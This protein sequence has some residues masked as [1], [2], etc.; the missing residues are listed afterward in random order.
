MPRRLKAAALSLALMGVLLLVAC[1]PRT[2]EPIPLATPAASPTSDASPTPEPTPTPVAVATTAPP[3][4]KEPLANDAE[5]TARQRRIFEQLWN[6]LDTQYVYADFNGV[7]WDAVYVEF[8]ARIEGGLS[9]EDFWRAMSEMID[10]LGDDHSTF[11]TP[12]EAREQDEQLGGTLTYIGIGVEAGVQADKAQA[13][14]YNV[15]PGSSAEQAGLRPHDA[16]LAIDGEAVVLP[17]GT[18]NLDKLRGELGS[19]V[20]L[21]VRSPG[22]LPRQVTL[23]RRRVN[24]TLQVT[25]RLLSGDSA[26]R[27]GYMM[28]PNLWDTAIESSAR[29][30]LAALMAGGRLDGLIIDMRTN[31]GGL[32]TNLLA[33]LGFFVHGSHGEFIGRDG[34]RALTV[35]PDPIGNSQ[36]VPLIILISEASVSYAEVFT[37]VLREAGRARL[38][39]QTSAGN[40]E[41]IYGYD[42]EDGSRAWI[43]RETFVPPSGDDWE[44]AGLD[45]DVRLD[46]D[47]DEFT[48]AND[49]A[50]AVALELLARP[51]GVIP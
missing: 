23:Q 15:F 44:N 21:T 16:I 6:T 48:E 29:E 20:A 31:N 32:S 11:L 24:G 35:T 26:G 4:T 42:F 37:G 8:S 49:P 40:I 9:D 3:V 41:T 2:P 1:A 51:A 25:G 50:I 33:L 36:E 28:V 7:D 34:V 19:S 10:R 22:G 14:I 43:A 30:T 27:I 39:G 17:D 46:A 13:V 5:A 45:P 18:D 38:V 12:A 47:W